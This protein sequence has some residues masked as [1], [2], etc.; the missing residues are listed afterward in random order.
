M[1]GSAKPNAVCGF[2][3]ALDA[4]LAELG[5]IAFLTNASGDQ[6]CL[7]NSNT[8]ALVNRGDR[9]YF[10]ALQKPRAAGERLRP[11]EIVNQQT[12]E[13]NWV[14]GVAVA[15]RPVAGEAPAEVREFL[16]NAGDRTAAFAFLALPVRLCPGVE[17]AACWVIDANGRM[18]FSNPGAYALSGL[19]AF[20]LVSPGFS[21]EARLTRPTKFTES[22]RLRNEAA[23]VSVRELGVPGA[24]EYAVA[25]VPLA[26]RFR[27][28]QHGLASIAR[29]ALVVWALP[30]LSLVVLCRMAPSRLID[31]LLPQ[32]SPRSRYLLGAITLLAFG[33]F[34]LFYSLRFLDP[35]REIRIAWAS[36]FGSPL[37][38]FALLGA[39]TRPSGAQP[40]RLQSPAW[41]FRWYVPAF[42]L[43]LATALSAEA[44]DL[45]AKGI[46]LALPFVAAASSLLPALPEI[47]KRQGTDTEA[48][49]VA[50]RRRRFRDWTLLAGRRPRIGY[51]AAVGAVLVFL[52][53][54]PVVLVGGAVLDTLHFADDQVA[55]LADAKRDGG[56]ASGEIRLSKGT[57][58]ILVGQ[59]DAAGE[60]RVAALQRLEFKQGRVW[61]ERRVLEP[62]LVAVLIVLLGT[63]GWW[64]LCRKTFGWGAEAEGPIS[65]G[66]DRTAPRVS[67]LETEVLRAVGAGWLPTWTKGRATRRL[68][69][70]GLLDNRDGLVLTEAG[71]GVILP[72]LSAP[73]VG[74][75]TT[76]P[77]PT[78]PAVKPA[79][80]L[81]LGWTYVLALAPV[82]IWLVGQPYLAGNVALWTTSIVSATKMVKRDG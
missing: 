59:F 68:L 19:N 45:G 29:S 66:A 41:Y 53:C 77:T 57:S 58:R 52:V 56:P 30:L 44:R 75:A 3:P 33:A 7:E 31:A 80:G 79:P 65:L 25:L 34:A 8:S 38:A 26:P 76:G 82:A 28:L 1:T 24:D 37:L 10:Q 11:V 70:Q 22:L 69:R 15:R 39:E 51:T 35:V 14:F 71:R 17:G 47:L 9:N 13:R 50:N 67:D 27:S 6:L 32:R 21:L 23:L 36:A 2:S 73:V 54:L 42:I 5:A 12:G 64:L 78:A 40:K 48:Q 16:V 62:S 49:R 74:Q 18:I 20:Q 60:R 72:P 81:G 63:T 55:A 4:E 43:V 46:V 61:A